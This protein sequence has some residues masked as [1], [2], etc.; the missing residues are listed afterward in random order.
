MYAW[1]IVEYLDDDMFTQ[2]WAGNESCIS[3]N[4]ASIHLPPHS[5]SYSGYRSVSVDAQMHIYHTL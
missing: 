4:I 5:Y 1:L 2:L 3:V